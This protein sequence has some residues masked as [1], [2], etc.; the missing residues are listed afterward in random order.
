MVILIIKRKMMTLSMALVALKKST[1]NNELL[2][3]FQFEVGSHQLAEV[4][5]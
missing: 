1:Q 2:D 5:K 3:R 4:R